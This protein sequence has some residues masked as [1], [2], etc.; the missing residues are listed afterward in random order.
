MGLLALAVLGPGLVSRVLRVAAKDALLV[1]AV[2]EAHEGVVTVFGGEGGA[3]VIAAPAD[4]EAE[5]DALVAD[6]TALLESQGNR[7]G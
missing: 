3:L 4:R 7:R 5:L 1:K 2:L 6:V